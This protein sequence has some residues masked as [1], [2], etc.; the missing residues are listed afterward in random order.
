MPTKKK[1]LATKNT[2]SKKNPL[3]GKGHLVEIF[4][5][6]DKIM[7]G[8]NT[9]IKLDGMPLP[10]ARKASFEVE[11]GK[12]AK[13]TLELFGRIRLMGSL[14]GIHVDYKDLVDVSK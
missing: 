4:C 1:N 9:K 8:A 10:Y 13:I 14:Q 11:G 7:C 5:D 3:V 12:L 6:P 2:D